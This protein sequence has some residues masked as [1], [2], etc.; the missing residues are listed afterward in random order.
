MS[1][2]MTSVQ[3]WALYGIHYQKMQSCLL[4]TKALKK[5]AACADAACLVSAGGSDFEHGQG[6]AHGHE[7]GMSVE[8]G[9][10]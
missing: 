7:E 1:S 8:L 10:C 6:H 9:D 2:V 5:N 4:T 3:G